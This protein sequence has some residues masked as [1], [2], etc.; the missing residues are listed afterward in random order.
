MSEDED[1]DM[2]SSLRISEADKAEEAALTAWLLSQQEARLGRVMGWAD[3]DA[4][5]PAPCFPH[6]R[7]AITCHP[8]QAA[9]KTWGI[10]GTDKAA[11]AEHR[12]QRLLR[13]QARARGGLSEEED[14]N[15]SYSS[16]GGAVLASLGLVAVVALR[17]RTRF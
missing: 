3:V 1:S 4:C 8:D 9:R 17:S 6:C 11:F 5:H 13:W 2:E 10:K 16:M 14:D 7:S 15:N 12:R